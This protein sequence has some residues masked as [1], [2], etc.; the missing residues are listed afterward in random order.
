MQTQSGEFQRKAVGRLF[1]A[2]VNQAILDLLEDAQEAEAAERWLLGRDF[3]KSVS[4]SSFRFGAAR[5]IMAGLVLFLFS[6][7]GAGT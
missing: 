5:T 7:P 4:L 3:A 6:Q 1:V 2:I